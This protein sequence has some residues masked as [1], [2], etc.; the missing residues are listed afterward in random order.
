MSKQFLKFFKR[1]TLQQLTDM[2][3][4]RNRKEYSMGSNFVPALYQQV[5]V[6]ML[7]SEDRAKLI[8]DTLQIGLTNRAA[9][10]KRAI[11]AEMQRRED[12]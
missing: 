6:E 1:D 2:G 12:L 3:V 7:E 11:R 5:K 10:H 4:L 9:A 8:E